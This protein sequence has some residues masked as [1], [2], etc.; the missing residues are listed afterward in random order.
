MRSPMDIM[1]HQLPPPPPPLLWWA[2]ESSCCCSLG[3]RG[4]IFGGM[5][6]GG[7]KQGAER[8]QARDGL[9]AF[10]GTRSGILAA[11]LA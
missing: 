11:S 1:F 6:G 2:P 7:Q 3:L 5:H 8:V 10:E 9:S 4:S